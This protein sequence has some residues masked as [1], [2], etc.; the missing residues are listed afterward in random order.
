MRPAT[1][2]RPSFARL[3]LPLA[4]G[5]GPGCGADPAPA[6]EPDATSEI[7][8][9]VGPTAGRWHAVPT[10]RHDAGLTDA[11]RAEIAELEALGYTDG[12]YEAPDLFGVTR[13]DAERVSPGV[14]LYTSAHAANAR[15]V[16]MDGKLLH[17]WSY[18]FSKVWPSY[19]QGRKLQTFWRR[20]HLFE[21]GDLLAIYEGLGLIKLDKDSNL[22]WASEVRAHHDLEVMPDGT[23]WV[24]TREAHMVPRVS[25]EKPVLEDYLSLLGPNGKELRRISLLEAMEASEFDADWSRHMQ[26]GGDLFHTN[27]LE[28]LDGRL[29]EANPAFAAG[30][31]LVSMLLLD[32][33][34]VVDPDANKVVWGRVGPYDAQHDP[35][36]LDNGRVLV[37]DNQGGRGHGAEVVGSRVLELDPATWETRWSYEGNEREPFYSETCGL[38]QRLP[39][40]NTLVTETDLG[41]AFEITSGGEIV[42]EFF[43]PHRAGDEDQYIATLMEVV[44]LPEDFP[45]DWVGGER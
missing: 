7:S 9:L 42:W 10:H 2:R 22:L 15:L 31:F 4:L 28:L 43:N 29:A 25:T 23:L 3:A 26:Y 1:T 18:P 35:Q 6:P 14:N 5:L 44:R 37:F 30:N 45:L 8:Y 20:T 40:G 17:E 13:H 27:S 34:A 41:R 16:D 19:P 38:A 33:V 12:K 11:Q 32:L 39:N 24:L 21:N 36:V